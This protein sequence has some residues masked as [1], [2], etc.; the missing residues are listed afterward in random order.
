MVLN[1][2]TFVG[3]RFDLAIAADQRGRL[4]SVLRDHGV[5]DLVLPAAATATD[6]AHEHVQAY[7][8]HQF[9]ASAHT[10]LEDQ[11]YPM[12]QAAPLPLTVP[13]RRVP[14][15]VFGGMNPCWLCNG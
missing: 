13:T 10:H 4:A 7:E 14:V 11:D 3:R 12:H 15:S 8:M 2:P 9:A 1:Q 6:A 5:D